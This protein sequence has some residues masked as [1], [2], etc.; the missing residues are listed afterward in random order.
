MTFRV[1]DEKNKK[2][3]KDNVYITPEGELYKL[4]KSFFGKTK[5]VPVTQDCIFHKA[6]NLSDKNGL[7]IF[8][9]DYL[10]AQISKDRMEVGL[11]VY[12]HELSSYVILC[13]DSDEFF[14]LGT[15]TCEFI[16]IVG[17]VFDG[18]IDN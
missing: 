14:T 12:A 1:Y 15:S 7:E 16:E 13:I 2:F 11:V 3:I 4:S 8:E 17:N 18:M 6:I 9:G 5:L 10:K